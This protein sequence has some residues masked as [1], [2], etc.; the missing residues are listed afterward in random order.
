MNHFLNVIV[1]KYSIHNT[2]SNNFTSK[3]YEEENKLFTLFTSKTEK[4]GKNHVYDV[5]SPARKILCIVFTK[6]IKDS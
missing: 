2:C 4:M 3:T 5:L 6:E 1:V